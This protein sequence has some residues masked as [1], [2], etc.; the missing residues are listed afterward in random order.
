[1]ARAVL[2]SMDAIK[3]GGGGLSVVEQPASLIG[4]L[5]S[6]HDKSADTRQSLETKPISRGTESSNPA[7]SSGESVSR[8]DMAVVGREPRGSRGC[9]RL[10]WRRGRQRRAGYFDIASTDGNISVGH[11][12]STAVL[13]RLSAALAAKVRSEVW[14]DSGQ[15]GV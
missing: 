6:P 2:E 9:A 7:P 1:L 14:L 5:N 8:G 3:T 15:A 10:L 4:A 13:P 11:Y 12:S